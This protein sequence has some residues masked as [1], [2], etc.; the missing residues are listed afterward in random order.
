MGSAMMDRLRIE[1]LRNID[2]VDLEI[3]S[4]A[5][6]FFGGNGAGK[7]S[8]LEAVY[9]LVRGRSFRGRKFGDLILRGKEV[10]RLEAEFVVCD[11]VAGPRL[12]YSKRGSESE[13]RVNGVA[14]DARG[15]GAAGVFVRLI[16]EGAF[17]LLEGEP[18]IRRNFLDL[19]LFHVEHQ[20]A[21]VLGSF[22]RA[23]DQRNA[24]LRG[25][26]PGRAI[27]DGEFV[28]R[29]LDLDRA[30]R[31][32]FEGVSREFSALATGFGF[33]E[34]AELVLQRGW[35]GDRTLEESLAADRSAEE[36]SGFTRVGPQRADFFVSS[37]S[38]PLRMSRGQEKLV[39]CLLQLA[40]D[41]E[42]ARRLRQGSVW[43]IDDLWADLDV[44]S[45]IKLSKLFADT[46]G[47][48]LFTKLGD[49]GDKGGSLWPSPTRMF[50]VERGAVTGV[51]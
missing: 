9:L 20:G 28:E 43:L 35:R 44:T 8:V 39:V 13:H 33:M 3:G 34:G 12:T 4:S 42:Q 14:F 7:T 45:S 49:A 31:A 19:N 47:Q 38:G 51:A 18:S 10:L 40:F 50:H 2:H 41:R 48:C 11:D 23:L 27:W 37:P 25:G 15:C 22:R 6:V 46:G 26:S 17:A 29:S 30:R 24:W 16:G 5:A 1:A 32:L 21:R 36:R